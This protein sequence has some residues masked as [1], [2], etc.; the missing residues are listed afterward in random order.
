MGDK[1]TAGKKPAPFKWPIRIAIVMLIYTVTGFFIVPA[2]VKS[3][4]LKRLPALTK[5]QA[6]IEDVK[7]NPY[8]LSLTIRGLALKET[9]GDVFTSFDEFY[10]NFQLWDSIFKRSW[11]FDE[12]TLPKPFAQITYQADGNFNFANLLSNIPATPKSPSAPPQALPSALIYSLSISNGSISVADLTRKEPFKTQFT[13]IDFVVTNLSTIRDKNSPYSFL[14]KTG[15][16]ET[17]AWAGTITLNPLRSAGVFRLGALQL[18]QFGTYSHDYVRFDIVS[19]LLDVAADYNY[20]SVTN[21]LDLNVSNAAVHL[22]NLQLKAPDTGEMVVVIPQLSVTDTAAS[23]LR[24]SARVGMVK[25]SGG[26][27]IVRQNGDGTINLLSLLNLPTNAPATEA[28]AAATVAP[29]L[30]AKIDEIAFDNYT[31]KAEDKKPAKPASFNIDQLAFDLKG[32]SNASNAPVKTSVS[33]RF[34]ET[35]SIAVNGT[36]TAFAAVGRCGHHHNQFG[37][38]RHPAIRGGANQTGHHQRRAGIAR[39][40]PIRSSAT[41]RSAH[42]FCGRFGGD[43]IRHGGRCIVQGFCEVGRAQRRRHP[44]ANAAG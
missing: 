1:S 8:V 9:N 14:A 21:M 28:K 24:R 29:P 35:G 12:I 44:N 6:S 43:E 22:T 32:V 19:G 18:P 4:M 15:S 13:P 7:C 27:L 2:I 10:A 20:D 34:Q 5:R 33:M 37:F 42:H 31:I 25:S 3:Q 38:A 39:A 40:R 26:S 41:R 16:G 11:V 30:S 36:V 23:V 17:F